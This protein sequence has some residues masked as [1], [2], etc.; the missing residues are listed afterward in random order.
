MEREERCALEKEK[1]CALESRG[2]T[3]SELRPLVNS[4]NLS[5]LLILSSK[6]CQKAKDESWDIMDMKESFRG[7]VSLGCRDVYCPLNK[8]L[9]ANSSLIPCSRRYHK[10]K[11]KGSLLSWPSTFRLVS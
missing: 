3:C 8:R 6:L 9:L 7:V 10:N 4:E 2:G 11:S 5:R 1:R